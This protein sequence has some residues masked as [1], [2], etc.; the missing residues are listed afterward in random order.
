MSKERVLR[1]SFDPQTIEHLG[2]K[3]YSQVPSAVAELIANSYDADA[4][5]V[6]VRLYDAGDEMKI[7]VSDNG[8]GMDF[9]EINEKFLRIGRNRRKEGATRS[10]RRNRKVTGKKGLGKLALFGIGDVIEVVTVKRDSGRKVTFVMDWK[11]LVNI[12]SGDYEPFYDDEGCENELHGTKIVLKKLRRKSPFDRNAFAMSL[13]KLFNFF[14]ANFKCWVYLND[15]DGIEVTNELKYEKIDAQFEWNFPEFLKGVRMEYTKKQEIRG[16]VISTEKPQQ[17]RLRGITLFANGRLVNEPEFFGVAESSHVFSY[18]TGW[19]DVDFVDDKEED[20][21]STNRR[22]LNWE[23]PETAALRECLTKTLRSIETDWSTKRREK[24]KEQMRQQT[25]V[26]I[27]EWYQTLPRDILAEIEAIVDTIVTDSELPRDAQFDT[28][29]RVHKLVPEYPYYHWRFLH[30]DVRDVSQEGY[31]QADYYGAFF[32]A[33]K[34]YIIEVKK[35]S[36]S[37]N[38]RAYPLM[39]EVFGKRNILSVTERYKKPNGDNFSPQ[40]TKNI[41]DGQ[42]LLSMG[43]VAGGRNP[44]SH[45]LAGDLRDSGLFSEKDCLDALSL[46][47]H[48]FRRLDNSVNVKPR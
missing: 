23:L 38:D 13:S 12:P 14:D 9:D 27:D 20:V 33:V 11:E 1:M 40:A 44:M 43:I 18:L 8:I 15:D 45:E 48:L 34:L 26:N 22:S 4:E 2:V 30:K 28:I 36:G 19:L 39:E 17:P 21:I 10:P 29:K 24:R 7:E 41:E 42:R 32:E 37:N 35:R 16:R 46:L 31:A 47:S 25:Q 6:E 5:K 3:M